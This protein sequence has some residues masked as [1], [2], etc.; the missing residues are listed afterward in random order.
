MKRDFG[1]CIQ[2]S[3]IA[4]FALM[5]VLVVC[6]LADPV[7]EPVAHHSGGGYY[8]GGGGML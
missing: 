2:K 1:F 8:G 6:V 7:P 5:A 3:V 4:V